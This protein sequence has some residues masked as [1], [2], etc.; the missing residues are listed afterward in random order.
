MRNLA[1]MKAKSVAS[2]SIAVVLLSGVI[3]VAG[4]RAGAESARYRVVEKSGKIEIRE[5]SPHV[6][7]TTSMSGAGESGSFGRLFQYISGENSAHEKI[8]MTTPVFMPATS[9]GRA[10]EM[11]FVVPSSVASAGA[12]KPSSNKVS[13]KKMPGG[14]YIAIRY[15][16]RSNSKVKKAKLEELRAHLKAEGLRSTGSPIFA[17]YDPPWTPAP[18]RRNEVLLKIR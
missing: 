16:G 14:R 18:V 3:F 1:T 11:Q 13:L 5:Y 12:P 10:T 8:A 2:W 17:G 9:D 15:N 7:A 6:V 4:L